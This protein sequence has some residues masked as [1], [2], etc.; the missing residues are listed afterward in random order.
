MRNLASQLRKENVELWRKILTHPFIVE[1]EAGLLPREKL[2]RYVKQD[3]LFLQRY[4]RCMAAAAHRAESY[5]TLSYFIDF[6]WT[7]LHDE[8][9]KQ[10]Q[11]A[12]SLG[13]NA[14]S[15]KNAK[16]SSV[17]LAYSSY[18]YRICSRASTPEIA[19]ALL[20]C[21]WTYQLLGCKIA[22]SLREKYGLSQRDTE[23]W[24]SYSS[25][26]YAQAVKKMKSLLNREASRLRNRALKNIRRNFRQSSLYEYQFWEHAYRSEG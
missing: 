3:H 8:V 1:L 9:E 22:R 25:R 20:P 24:A 2:I 13:L 10:I 15:L 18:L 12:R 4:V 6:A 16:P 11:F 17:T 23:W 7:A 26:E 21:M 19:A 5:N 14:R